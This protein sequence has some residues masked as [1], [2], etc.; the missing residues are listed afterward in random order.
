MNLVRVRII[1]NNYSVI[2]STFDFLLSSF[3]TKCIWR[4][5]FVIYVLRI[6][7]PDTKGVKMLESSRFTVQRFVRLILVLHPR[8]LAVSFDEKNMQ[9]FSHDSLTTFLL[10]KYVYFAF[11]GWFS[12]LNLNECLLLQS[13]V[14]I[15]KIRVTLQ[16]S[17]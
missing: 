9:I 5:T 4:K 6:R 11:T 2:L 3:N 16:N 10:R 7:A 12:P 8:H 14:A 15:R 13:F 17:M 1:E